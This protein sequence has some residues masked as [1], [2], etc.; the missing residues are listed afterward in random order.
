MMTTLASHRFGMEVSEYNR[1]NLVHGGEMR[2]RKQKNP[3]LWAGFF[4][5]SGAGNEIRTRD[6]N[7]GK[8]VLYQLSYSRRSLK[9]I[10]CQRLRILPIGRRSSTVFFK[11]ILYPLLPEPRPCF[12]VFQFPGGRYTTKRLVAVR[13]TTKPGNDIAMILSRFKK[14]PHKLPQ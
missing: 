8:V 4:C 11:K 2:N 12:Q 7:L 1:R 5:E 6:P 10:S 13:E 3:A 14:A 9:A